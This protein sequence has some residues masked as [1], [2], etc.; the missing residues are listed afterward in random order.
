[1]PALSDQ[2]GPPERDTT[3]RGL[4]NSVPAY[5]WLRD[6]DPGDLPKDVSPQFRQLGRS[7]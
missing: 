3:M 4:R 5:G 6:Y 7:S 1:V 2:K